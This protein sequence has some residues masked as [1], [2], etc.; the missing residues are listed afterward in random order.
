MAHPILSIMKKTASFRSSLSTNHYPLSNLYWNAACF[1]AGAFIFGHSLAQTAQANTDSDRVVVMISVDGLGAYYLDDPKADM[2]TIRALAADGARAT[3]MKASTPTVTWPNHTTL[4]TGVT[5]AKHG[6]LGNNYF[7][8]Q[9]RKKVTLISDPVYDKDEIVKVPTIYDLAKTAGLKTAGIRWPATRNAKTLDWTIPDVLTTNLLRKYTTPALFADCQK[10]GIDVFAGEPAEAGSGSPPPKPTDQTCTRVFNLILHEHHPHLALLHVIDV[11]HTEHL[12]GPK[13]PEA[14]AAVKVA[15]DEVGQ[16]WEELKRDYPERATLLVV[17]DHGFSPINRMILPNIILRKAG[18]IEPAGK[19]TASTSVQ[20]V[21][22]GGLEMVYVMD[23]AHRADLM[24]RVKKA[25]QGVEGI[26]KIVGPKEFE[27]YGI[28]NP[29]DDPH[30]PDMILFA[31]EGC[32]FGD[33]AA[34]ELPF[35]DKPERKGSHGH[36]PD[37][38]DLHATFVAW[39]AGIKHGVKLGEIPNTDVAPTIA[40][41]L[42]LSIPN[43]D[44]KVLKDV[45][46]EK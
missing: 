45:L 23:D 3:M 14:Y 26:S 36:D 34:G 28:A 25:F 27:Y 32:T 22:Q 8:R 24:E 29:K 17:S 46:A 10:A 43:P 21:S 30:A 33:T 39:G 42:G 9:T 15:D 13:T 37:L 40:K 12:K 16:V 6:V 1:L 4:V 31:E 38:P 41:L 2:P 7:D 35:I 5:P 11:D 18:L 20:L 19:K 44:G